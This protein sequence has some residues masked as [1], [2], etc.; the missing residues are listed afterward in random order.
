MPGRFDV[1]FADIK[2][3][4]VNASYSVITFGNCPS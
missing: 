2:T 3:D 4:D 1:F